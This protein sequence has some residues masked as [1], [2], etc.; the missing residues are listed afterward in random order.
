MKDRAQYDGRSDRYGV[1]EEEADQLL[2]FN[3]Q[4]REARVQALIATVLPCRE[5][6]PRRTREEVEA[7]RESKRRERHWR[8]IACV[9]PHAE[10]RKQ[11]RLARSQAL[12]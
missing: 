4:E 3:R 10:R 11:Q 9:Y 6:R 1:A 8:R 2:L 5:R 12:T 7:E